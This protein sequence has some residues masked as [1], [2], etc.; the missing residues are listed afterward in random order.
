MRLRPQLQRL[1]EQRMLVRGQGTWSLTDAGRRRLA[2]A[3][4]RGEKIE[5]PE[6]PQHLRWRLSRERALEHLF[7]FREQL[8]QTLT[9]AL[10]L[11]DSEQ[12]QA[13]EWGELSL[14]LRQQAALLGW[15][16]YCIHDWSE[17]QDEKADVALAE[18]RRELKLAV[19]DLSD[20][21][22]L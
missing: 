4:R 20:I 16:L 8:R 21:F 7:G 2:R 12:Q 3:R 11:I 17:P 19:A 15:A 1:I 6:S 9:R 5:L 18:R 22:P 13:Q 14:L 10:A